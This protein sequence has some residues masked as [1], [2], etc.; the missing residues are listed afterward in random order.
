[1]AGNDGGKVLGDLLQH[2][3]R[4]TTKFMYLRHVVLLWA[5]GRSTGELEIVF[6]LPDRSVNSV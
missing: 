4:F 2:A 3:I 6:L 5:F 1:M